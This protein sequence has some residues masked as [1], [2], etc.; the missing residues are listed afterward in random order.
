M[1]HWECG[2]SATPQL[3]P[4]GTFEPLVPGTVVACSDVANA[5]SKL[6]FSH[7]AVFR[8]RSVV[9]FVSR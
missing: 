9:Q 4:T 2:S 6:E 1:H 5:W 8:G 3:S 7:L